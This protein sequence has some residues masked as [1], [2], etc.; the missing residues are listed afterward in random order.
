MRRGQVGHGAVDDADAYHRAVAALEGEDEG[1]D[2]H[3]RETDE[4][5]APVAGMQLRGEAAGDAG[6]DHAGNAVAGD[7]EAALHGCEAEALDIAVRPRG[8]TD[9]DEHEQEAAHAEDQL[10][11][12][13]EKHT[14]SLEHA[15]LLS[16]RRR[17]RALAVNGLDKDDYEHRDDERDSSNSGKGAAP[18]EGLVHRSADGL[19]EGDAEGGRG[20][21]DA[22]GHRALLRREGDGDDLGALG[23]DAAG[24]DAGDDT[25]DK[26]HLIALEQGHGAGHEAA[27]DGADEQ[28][29]LGLILVGK[30]AAGDLSDQIAR[31]RT[32]TC[33]GRPEWR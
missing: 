32:R 15:G 9:R 25:D 11:A 29:V 16:L 18:A 26:T 23:H 5:K 19:G 24:A 33:K 17:S 4:Q 7:Y 8:K 31:Q 3:G 20:Q 22:H 13:R 30:D 10:L 28:D 2:G 14:Q 1:H 6:T 27:K 21:D 12:V